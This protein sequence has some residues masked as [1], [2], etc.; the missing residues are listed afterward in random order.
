MA[1]ALPFPSFE[2]PPEEKSPDVLIVA[3]EHSGDQHAAELVHALRKEKPD[4]TISCLGGPALKAAGVQLLFD[5]TDSS[6]VGF[7]EVVKHYGF[8]KQLFKETL[9]W[10]EEWKP[11]V[12]CFID[13]PGFNLRLADALAK[14]KLTK[15]SGGDITLAYY[16]S[17]QIWAWKGKRRFKMAKLLDSLAVIFPFEVDC[18]KDTDLP[19]AFVGHPYVQEGYKSPLTYDITAPVLMTPG[20]RKQAISRIFPRMLNAFQAFRKSMP[21]SRAIVPYPTEELKLYLEDILKEYPDIQESVQLIPFSGGMKASAV[22]ASSGTMS[23][24]CALAGIPGTIC[25]VAHPWTY[26]LGRMLV[27][28]EYLGIANLLLPKTPI[29]REYLQNEANVDNLLNELNAAYMPDQVQNTQYISNRLKELLS[30]PADHSPA[31]WL[32]GLLNGD[33]LNDR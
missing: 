16:I 27:K 15:K 18:Y 24:T 31:Q 29:Y 22:L 7:V 26:R 8:F 19:V 2:A 14:K 13:Y 5:L 17:P 1:K 25:Y 32:L 11:K 4:A 6:V 12:I 23:L 21:G 10:I 9:R 30:V 28:I 20:S 3:G 33:V